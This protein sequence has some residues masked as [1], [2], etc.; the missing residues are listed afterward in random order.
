[1]AA[2]DGHPRI[3]IDPEIMVGKPCISGTRIP[4]ELILMH[5]A[6]GWTFE[7]ITKEYDISNEDIRAA[8]SYAATH[9]PRPLRDAAE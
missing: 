6:A 3:S 8:V 1:M 9:L 5:V 4:V 7:V 2:V